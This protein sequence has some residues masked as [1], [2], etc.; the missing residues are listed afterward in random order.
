MLK[1]FFSTPLLFFSFFAQAQEIVP[2]QVPIEKDK[3]EAVIP[4]PPKQAEKPAPPAP[5]TDSIPPKKDRYGLRVGV[6]L[7]KLSRSFYDSNYKGIEFTADYRLTKRHYFAVEAGVEDKT[8]ED[9]QLVTTAKGTYI[10]AGLDYNLYR[11]WLDMENIISIGLRYG[12]SSFSQQMDSYKVYDAYPYWGDMSWVTSGENHTGLI[13]GWAEAV[14]GLKVKVF[15]NVF[16]GFSLQM[17]VLL[18][19]TKPGDYDN[20]YIPGFNRTYDGK[21]GAGFNY[22]VS[23]FIPLYKRIVIPKIIPKKKKSPQ[24][25]PQNKKR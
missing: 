24:D 1:Y 17:K 16:V 22:S 11:N 10:K 8:T 6:D 2:A 12:M 13:A 15:N 5:K 23:Y 4:D 25:N 21:I 19:D 18:F 7:F 9:D 3:T 20:L 14:A